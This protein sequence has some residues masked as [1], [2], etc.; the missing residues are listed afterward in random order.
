LIVPALVVLALASLI[1]ASLTLLIVAVLASLVVAAL[2]KSLHVAR[3]PLN[4]L[5]APLAALANA[6][7]LKILGLSRITH[8]ENKNR[9]E[10]VDGI[11]HFS[12]RIDGCACSSIVT[13]NRTSIFL[14]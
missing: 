7:A 8:H 2:A 12:G 3:K 6:R 10:E 1:V 13:S 5:M 14:H 9:A 4:H 11:F